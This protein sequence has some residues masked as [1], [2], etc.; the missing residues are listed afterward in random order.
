MRVF[1]N[2]V[3]WRVPGVKAESN[4]RLEGEKVHNQE[5]H[6]SHSLNIRIIMRRRWVRQV[7]CMCEITNE[8]NLARQSERKRL[9]GMH[10]WEDNIKMEIK[11]T[12]FEYVDC[13]NLV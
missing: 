3:P 4:R 2:R 1:E 6:N 5:L 11:E 10:R 12:G 7:A 9:N 8:K 13:I